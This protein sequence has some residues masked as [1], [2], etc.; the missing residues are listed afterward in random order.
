MR[1][2]DTI[3]LKDQL[4]LVGVERPVLI[5]PPSAT[6]WTRSTRSDCRVLSA[7]PARARP[8]GSRDDI[9]IVAGADGHILVLGE[10]S[11]GKEVAVHAI[12]TFSGRGARKLVARSAATTPDTLIDVELLGNVGN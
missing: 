8:A 1:A 2:G 3:T 12:H 6:R 5:P 11:V 7:S 10:S 4:M 9:A